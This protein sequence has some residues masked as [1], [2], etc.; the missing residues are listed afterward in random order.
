MKGKQIKKGC[1]RGRASRRDTLHEMPPRKPPNFVLVQGGGGG[2]ILGA[3]GGGK[4]EARLG[5]AILRTS[6]YRGKQGEMTKKV[7]GAP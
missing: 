1:A 3:R 2:G 5:D 4:E 6:G 7:Q